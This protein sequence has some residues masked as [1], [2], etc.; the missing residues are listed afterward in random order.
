MCTAVLTA[1]TPHP[2]PHPPHLGAY[3]RA[4]LVS[5]NRRHL[6]VTPWLIPNL[7]VFNCLLTSYFL[8]NRKIHVFIPYL[9]YFLYNVHYSNTASFY[10]TQKRP[11]FLFSTSIY[12]IFMHLYATGLNLPKQTWKVNII[13]ANTEENEGFKFIKI[14]G[15]LEKE[16][17]F[18]STHSSRTGR[19]KTFNV[20]FEGYI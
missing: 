12:T 20:A 14:H 5:Q 10:E 8:L 13:L 11:F 19:C 7:P 6:F 9:F 15:L 17:F 2:H 4:L 3:T 16:F 18:Y 1:E